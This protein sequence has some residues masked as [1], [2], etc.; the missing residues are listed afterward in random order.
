VADAAPRTEQVGTVV[1]GEAAAPR[2]SL[3]CGDQ[4]ERVRMDAT[5]RAT[6]RRQAAS[7][8]VIEIAERL[9][10]PY[11]VTLVAR[12]TDGV[13]V[14]V[15]N[16]SSKREGSATGRVLGTTMFTDGHAMP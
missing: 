6:P 2:P 5:T 4:A 1:R 14:I 13:A 12:P 16:G 7:Q 8:A 10:R 11:R 9:W 3:R 15:S